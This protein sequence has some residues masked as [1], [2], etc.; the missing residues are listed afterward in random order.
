M[1]VNRKA[2]LDAV[3]LASTVTP[4]SVPNES[5]KCIHL[6]GKTLTATDQDKILSINLV[7]PVPD[8][9]A[10]PA[11]L[12]AV[13]GYMTEDEIEL[14]ATSGEGELVI[15]CDSGSVTLTAPPV[16]S[17]SLPE[18]DREGVEHIVDADELATM[19]EFCQ[20][21]ADTSENGRYALEGVNFEANDF[22]FALVATDSKR[23]STASLAADCDEF[24]EV[25]ET[26]PLAVITL[27]CK[28]MKLHEPSTVSFEFGSN[29]VVI[30]AGDVEILTPYLAGNYPNAQNILDA[31]HGET[32]TFSP[33]D[34][35]P[36]LQIA[37]LTVGEE[38]NAVNVTL[39]EDGVS[40]SSHTSTNDRSELSARSLFGIEGRFS[41]NAGFLKD[42]LTMCKGNELELVYQDPESAIGF[43]L[44]DGRTHVIMP[45]AAQ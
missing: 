5:F 40:F 10:Y 4:K 14:S 30:T 36:A 16:S 43:R 38:T 41:V 2:L 20:L 33:E 6:D 18:K 8:C 12:A 44:D 25:R 3:K 22:G 7:D 31:M 42:I 15:T 45:V 34:V 37:C 26:I 13:L 32:L 39:S 24:I 27:L 9:L 28:A 19:L 21:A 11:K 17:F 23:L 29:T 1:R 35:L